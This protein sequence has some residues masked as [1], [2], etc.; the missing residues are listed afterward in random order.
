MLNYRRR[1]TRTNAPR[2][3]CFTV[4]SALIYPARYLTAQQARFLV[5]AD[6]PVAGA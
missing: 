2:Y 1:D 4:I 6:W 3:K 5:P